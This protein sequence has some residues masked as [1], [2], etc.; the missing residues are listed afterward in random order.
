MSRWSRVSVVLLA[1]MLSMALVA[2]SS[3]AE[4]A[5]SPDPAVPTEAT[6]PTMALVEQKCSLCHTTQR[7]Y[8]V[9]GDAA[10]WNTIIDR[11]E[12]NGLVITDDERATIVEYLSGR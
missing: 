9:D 12:T 1:L 8:D 2:C 4:P 7:V 10:E 6:D 5:E 3:P 11:M